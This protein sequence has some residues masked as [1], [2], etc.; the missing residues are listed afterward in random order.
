M[1]SIFSSPHFFLLAFLILS[2]MHSFLFL[3]SS[4]LILDSSNILTEKNNNFEI[5][6][7]NLST[8]PPSTWLSPVLLFLQNSIH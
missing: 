5:T 2:D 1:G 4:A 3:A 7:I 8:N 6:Y